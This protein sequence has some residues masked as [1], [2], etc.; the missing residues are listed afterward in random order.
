M[1]AYAKAWLQFVFPFYVWTI[2]GVLILLSHYSVK[3]AR[4]LGPNPVAVMATLFLL[5]YARILRA[6]VTPLSAAFLGYSE[7]SEAVWVVDGNVRYLQ[8]KHIPLFLMA[9]VLLVFL[10]LPYTL[11]LLF[12][13]WIQRF[14][15]FRWINSPRIRPFRDAYCAPYNPKHRYWNGLLLLLRCIIFIVFGT[16]NSRSTGVILIVITC[17]CFGLTSYAWIVGVRIYKK[18]YVEALEASH[19]KSQHPFGSV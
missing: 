15:V 4:L 3:V 13:Q 12:G 10:F 1:D 18:W 11:L 8:G 2:V 14:K 5:S 16:L 6:I 7:R 17:I 9:L 19:S